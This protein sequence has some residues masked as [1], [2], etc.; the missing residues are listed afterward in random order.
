MKKIILLFLCFTAQQVAMAADGAGQ[1]VKP[2][3]SI[4]M[5]KYYCADA[6]KGNAS[7]YPLVIVFHKG[8]KNNPGGKAEWDYI[9]SE[10]SCKSV[11]IPN[12]RLNSTATYSVEMKDPSSVIHL[13]MFHL[14]WAD[15]EIF[16]KGEGFIAKDEQE[17]YTLEFHLLPDPRKAVKQ[18]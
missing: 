6:P 16:P 1:L 12:L 4:K 18:N 5:E 9:V 8:D 13:A 14:M 17:P 7:P 11:Y 15:G 2:G 3:D 10:T